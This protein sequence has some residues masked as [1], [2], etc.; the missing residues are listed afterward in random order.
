MVRVRVAYQKKRKVSGFTLI[1]ML[2]S[3]TILVIGLVGVLMVIPV[4]QRTTG[5]SALATRA[6]IFAS[7]KMEELK[8]K[9]YDDLISAPDRSG[10]KDIFSWNAKIVDVV[11]SDFQGTVALPAERFVKIHLTVTYA[12]LGKQR[13]ETFVTFYSEL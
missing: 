7:E 4:G 8:V 11:A 12:S 6:A 1:E 9:G 5:R 13:S 10:T 2:I 3:I